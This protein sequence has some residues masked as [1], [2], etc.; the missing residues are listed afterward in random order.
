MPLVLVLGAIVLAAFLASWGVQATPGV[1]LV[2][3]LDRL[4]AVA[5]MPAVY[6]ASGIGLGR[7]VLAALRWPQGHS[8]LPVQAVAG[9]AFTLFLSHAAG[10]LGLF[11]GRAGSYVAIALLTPGLVAGALQAFA[12]LRRGIEARASLLAAPAVVAGVVLLVAACGT[13]GYLWSSEFGGYDALSYHLQL[14]REWLASG[15]ISPLPHNVYS[16]LPGYLEAAFLH[17][18]A[19]SFPPADDGLIAGDGERLIA[20]QLLHA[21]LALLAAWVTGH[22]AGLAAR[23]VGADEPR[24]HLAA[25]LA[26]SLVLATP[27]AVVTGSLAYNDMGVVAIFAGAVV[28]TLCRAQDASPVARGALLGLLV[29]T[30]CSVKLTAVLFV[31]VPVA[32]LASVTT[33]RCSWWRTSIACAAVGVVVVSPWLLRN[34]AASGDPVFPFAAGLFA[35]PDG[36]LGHWSAEQ[37]ARYAS[38][39]SFDG[40]WP[41]RLRLLVLPDESD[42]AGARHRGLLHPQWGAFFLL[43]GAGGVGAIVTTR[44][45]RLALALIAMLLLQLALWLVATHI[46]SR[47]LLPALVP[48]SILVALSATRLHAGVA[49]GACLLLASVQAGVAL[50]VY[51]SEGNGRPAAALVFWPSAQTGHDLTLTEAQGVRDAAPPVLFVNLFL[52]RDAAVYLLGDATP[53]Y[54]RHP[55]VYNTTW[56]AWPIGAA[57]ATFPDDPGAWNATLRSRGVA[58][59]LVNTAEINRLARSGWIDPRV[60]P[61]RIA[62]WM[63]S[64]TTL[65]RAWPDQGVFLVSIEPRNLSP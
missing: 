50:S 51:A 22:A 5:W 36:S 25:L 40:S 63:T 24:A 54:H 29:A 30:A 7:P 13:P 56:D 60:Q 44:G 37:V 41:E 1:G 38:A 21:A 3:L 62:D 10:V 47:F 31:L 18:G 52:P 17:L 12:A 61:D 58:Y 55:V 28:V 57:A 26:G 11:A 48:G 42:P 27:W 6:V 45:G 20:C 4:L 65:V 9:M 8:R 15:R 32:V 39:H 2:F 49:A 34:Y 14:P 64:H 16:F 43:A 33:P 46:Q 59:V 35:K 53:L 23:H 19:L